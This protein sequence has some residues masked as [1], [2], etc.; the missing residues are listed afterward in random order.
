MKIKSE[1]TKLVVIFKEKFSKELRHKNYAAIEVLQI[2]MIG[3]LLDWNTVYEVSEM[4][5]IPK[6]KLYN[7]LATFKL[8][9]W[10]KLFRN[11]FDKLAIKKLQKLQGQSDSTWSRA[12]VQISVDDS[13]IRR[14][15]KTLSFL[16]K[17]WSGQFH[18]V[19][20]GQD[21]VLIILKI[22]EE[23]IPIRFFLMSKR[24]RYTNRHKVV[25]NLMKSISEKWTSAGIDIKNIPISM[26]AGYADHIEIEEINKLGF[27]KI[28]FGVK[29]NYRVTK[30][31]TKHMNFNLNE[32]ITKQDIKNAETK[33][34]WAINENVCIFKG[35]SDCFGLVTVMGRF[36][37]GKMRYCFAKNIY[38]TAEILRVWKQHH[39]IEE[40][41][42][43][44][45]HLLS[46]GKYRLRGNDGAYASI[47][48]SFFA[49]YAVLFLQKQTGL[50]FGQIIREFEKWKCEDVN[51]IFEPLNL[52]YISINICKQRRC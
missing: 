34:K 1:Y 10:R 48:L 27:Q 43:R 28:L 45:K 51:E 41:F 31:R 18:E 37:L 52:Q 49:Y 36:M 30:K 15:G 14:Y 6:D 24:G 5:N 12:G 39:W 33:G 46:W 44:L 9:D 25:E 47:V 29:K 32:I 20:N 17:W 26:D 23:I 35:R 8:R 11:L 2:L 38:R 21:I 50:T 13:V 42:K 19:L 4:L 40:V 3:L 22:G 16:G 7:E